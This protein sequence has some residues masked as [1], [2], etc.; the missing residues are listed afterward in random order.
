MAESRDGGTNV[1]PEVLEWLGIEYYNEKI[2]RPRRNIS[3]RFEKRTTQARSNPIT[4]F[5]SATRPQS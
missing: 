1:P 2:F 4:Y 5:I 3:A